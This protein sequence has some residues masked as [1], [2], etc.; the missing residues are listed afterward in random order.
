MM[1]LEG[2][3]LR[4]TVL[5]P[6]CVLGTLQ[7]STQVL[8]RFAVGWSET[9]RKSCNEFHIKLKHMG[10]LFLPRLTPAVAAGLPSL[11]FHLA[12]TGASDLAIAGPKG[13]R[14]LMD[15]LGQY[16][17]RKYPVLATEEAEKPSNPWKT[18]GPGLRVMPIC[19]QRSSERSV[20]PTDRQHEEGSKRQRIEHTTIGSSTDS[21]C[22]LLQFSSGT[23][24]YQ[25]FFAYVDSR[26][27]LAALKEHSV[28]WQ[29]VK[30][31]AVV[32]L[33][34][35]EFAKTAEYIT[36]FQE[37]STDQHLFPHSDS[38]CH[39]GNAAVD[40]VQTSPSWVRQQLVLHTLCPRG[41]PVPPVLTSVKTRWQT[42]E[43]IRVESRDL[44]FPRSPSL[45]TAKYLDVLASA[46]FAAKPR[47]PRVHPEGLW[48]PGRGPVKESEPS[49]VDSGGALSPDECKSGQATHDEPRK[50]S[51]IEERKECRRD[52]VKAPHTCSSDNTSSSED[53]SSESS[54]GAQ[55]TYSSDS[56][57]SASGDGKP[58]SCG[59]NPGI[60]AFMHLPRCVNMPADAPAAEAVH[61]SIDRRFE[62]SLGN[63]MEWVKD[64]WREAVRLRDDGS[65]PEF[66]FSIAPKGVVMLG[67]G[68]ASPSKRRSCSAIYIPL[69]KAGGALLD[70]GE[71]AVSLLY[72]L[73][74]AAADEVSCEHNNRCCT[75][76]A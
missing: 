61:V 57:T 50:A 26:E 28:Q 63:R 67:T 27:S 58:F 4:I 2:A 13:L 39:M 32:H 29:H 41:F 75:L 1:S 6:T 43:S 51:I 11:L 33:S 62:L 22:F 37:F 16:V 5:S 18:I 35:C 70:A 17:K 38:A 54:E 65:S 31:A 68:A 69:H 10:A 36:Y 45:S 48:I 8:S 42:G 19:P 46:V 14:T 73:F 72:R 23:L 52:T 66:D 74:G 25:V 71:G 64:A 20:A 15:N 21:C 34:P 40:P 44:T 9:A 60:T 76:K 59:F 53:G 56:E 7:S 24:L 47:P 12:D 3:E 30:L 49:L 55:E